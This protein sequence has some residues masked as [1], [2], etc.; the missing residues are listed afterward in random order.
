MLSGV[1][2]VV[3][4]QIATV[5]ILLL[6]VWACFRIFEPGSPYLEDFAGLLLLAPLLSF[7]RFGLLTISMGGAVGMGV[8]LY[9]QRQLNRR[10][11][12]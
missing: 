12:R 5:E 1:L 11:D 7:K 9:C 6:V 3:L 4:V 2:T 10:P 8:A